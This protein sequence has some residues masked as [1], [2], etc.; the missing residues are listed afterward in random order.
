M[1]RRAFLGLVGGATALPFAAR[2]QQSALP[3]IGF[4]N[5][6]SPNTRS[7]PLQAFQQ[8][9]KAA[10]FIEGQ[11]VVIE[12]RW[13]QGQNERLPAFAADLVRRRLS[14]IAAFGDPSVMAIKATGTA[15][16]VVFLV[17]VDPVRRGLVASLSRPGG[18]LTGAITLN[19][20]LSSKRLEIIHQLTPAATA[21]AVLVNPTSRSNTEVTLRD[22][23]AASQ[24]L[25]LKL[26]VFRASTE[27]D[28]VTAF[29]ALA[30]L[31][32][33]GLVIG[34]DGFFISRSEQLAAFALRHKVP[35]IFHYREFVAAGG[36][37]S[38]G[39]SIADTY[40]QIGTYAGRILKGEKPADLPVVQSTKVELIINTK[41]AK[42]LG[43]N[44][45]LSLL[46]RADEVI[47]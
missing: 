44:V 9:L 17:A 42:A 43:L 47:E 34:T 38:Y 11:N 6:G 23:Q 45:P 26:Q 31:Q 36:L 41:T 13:A 8:G 5:N 4:L 22:M 10:G 18:N 20:G 15:I 39:T 46:G 29:A 35:A 3:V 12:Y 37:M 19:V 27:G 2:A 14:V 33:C 1:R 16:P 7:F 25:A 28:I 40:Q 32:P 21:V 30:Q 24:K